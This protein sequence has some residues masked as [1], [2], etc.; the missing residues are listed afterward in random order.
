MNVIDIILAII[1]AYS[2]YKGFKNGVIVELCGILGIIVGIY[3]A[4]YF[5]DFFVEYIDLPA[6]VAKVLSFAGVLIIVI[7]LIGIIARLISKMLD[8]S[9][10][11]VLNRILGSIAA[12]FKCAIVLSILVSLFLYLNKRTEWVSSKVV[13]NSIIAETL[14]ST[15]HIIFPY[16]EFIEEYYYEFKES[17]KDNNDNESNSN[18]GN[19]EL[20]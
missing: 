19:R 2:L 18:Q 16:I 10:L 14:Q 17:I 1:L 7:A 12:F 4:Y 15:S 3:L 11:G 9:G 13:Q 5:S 6:E 8:F 20:V